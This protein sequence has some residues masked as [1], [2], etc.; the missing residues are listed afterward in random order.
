MGAENISRKPIGYN[1]NL[2]TN[3][4][5]CGQSKHLDSTQH[6]FKVI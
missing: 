1:P 3:K 5:E 4:V 6:E 2:S